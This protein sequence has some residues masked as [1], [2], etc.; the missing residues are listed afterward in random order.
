MSSV[1][2]ARFLR[3]AFA[4]GFCLTAFGAAADSPPPQALTAADI[5]RL[6]DRLMT[7]WVDDHKGPGA[8]VVVVT[9]D[10]AWATDGAERATLEEA[11]AVI[12][13][14]QQAKLTRTLS[15]QGLIL[16]G[17]KPVFPTLGDRQGNYWVDVIFKESKDAR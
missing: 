12:K 7:K 11:L 5:G 4:A 14:E 9:R 15:E 13:A 1:H 17:D 8:V 3:L 10:A 6:V 16:H 2:A